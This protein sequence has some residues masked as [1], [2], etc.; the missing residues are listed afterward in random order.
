MAQIEIYAKPSSLYRYRRLG[1]SA[2]QE[3]A[4]LLESYVYCPSYSDLNDPME[5]KHRLSAR[6]QKDPNF[7]K[8]NSRIKAA[9]D[10]LGVASFSEVHNHEPMWA[11]YA[12]EFKGMC[13]QYNLNKLLKGLGPGTAITRMM[14]SK[15]EPVLIDDSSNAVDR[16]RKC[17]SS[18]TVRW[19][20]EREWRVF[21]ERRGEAGYEERST[22]TRIYLG[23]RV[24]DD[25][26]ATVLAAAK[27]I[28]VPVSKMDI[29]AYALEF[30]LL[31]APVRRKP[32]PR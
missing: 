31:W 14:Y 11:H 9:F 23:S 10:A 15:Q 17:L 28:G 3:I 16:A 32:K 12:D 8:S 18:K 29:N 20:S 1:E 24:S 21:S 4:A 5:G 22:V 6:L 30:K 19:A 25:D 7:G 13:I 2:A 26:E 27:E